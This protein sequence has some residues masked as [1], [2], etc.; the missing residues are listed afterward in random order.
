M[1][2]HERPFKTK[3]HVWI[4]QRKQLAGNLPE[5]PTSTVIR[6]D[7]WAHLVWMKL[8][9][10]G[11]INL[12]SSNTKI[13]ELKPDLL[14]VV[15]HHKPAPSLRE[16]LAN[17][18]NTMVLLALA[19]TAL[20]AT[21]IRIRIISNRRG[22]RAKGAVKRTIPRRQALALARI[23]RTTLRRLQPVLVRGKQMGKG[24]DTAKMMDQE[25]MEP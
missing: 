17:N 7:R 9:A 12:R 1:V 5:A 16:S 11:R 4:T 14:T 22:R 20:Q 13:H 2:S 18:R 19:V 23:S 25:D 3:N 10:V 8:N 15:H 21:T 6:V 24:N